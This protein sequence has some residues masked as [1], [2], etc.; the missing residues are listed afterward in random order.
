MNVQERCGTEMS[1]V[2]MAI[3]L[4]SGC[5][6]Y[7][8]SNIIREVVS[9]PL[10]LD[11]FHERI[12]KGWTVAAVEWRKLPVEGEQPVAPDTGWQDIPYGQRIAPD[13][14]HLV[15][16]RLE[17]DVLLSIYEKVVAGWRPTAIATELNTRGY[18]TRHGSHWT[19]GAVFDLLPRL[20]ELS[21]RL[22]QRPDWPSRR[23][24]LAIIT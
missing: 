10:T 17:T 22:Q 4:Q 5:Q 9:E 12:A 23:A 7:S 15:E 3:C 8:M 11:Y 14:G 21:P 20:I 24:K 16:D 2:L 1:A 6:A 18:R 19:P 13:C